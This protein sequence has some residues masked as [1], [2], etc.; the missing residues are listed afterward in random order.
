MTDLALTTI[1]VQSENQPKPAQA[2]ALALL[3][4]IGMVAAIAIIVASSTPTHA[5]HDEPVPL[6]LVEDDTPKKEEPKPEPVKPVSKII[7][8]QVTPLRQIPIVEP[9]PARAEIQTDVQT[10]FAD[11]APSPPCIGSSLSM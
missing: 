5:A 8:K 11:P 10:A 3:I 2:F 6:T 9:V 7:P 4:E 1:A